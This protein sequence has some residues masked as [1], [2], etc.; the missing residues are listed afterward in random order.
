[1]M[2]PSSRRRK[3]LVAKLSRKAEPRSGKAS[4]QRLA[5]RLEA[6]RGRSSSVMRPSLARV[7]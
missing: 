4:S 1:M 2:R 3:S 6:M 5:A 7:L